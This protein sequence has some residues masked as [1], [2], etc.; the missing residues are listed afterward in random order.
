MSLLIAGKAAA[1]GRNGDALADID[2]AAADILDSLVGLLGP[3]PKPQAETPPSPLTEE[4]I[5]EVKTHALD[6]SL[7]AVVKRMNEMK[8]DEG[9]E[10]KTLRQYESF[11]SLFS[12]LTGIS[13]VIYNPRFEGMIETGFA[14]N[15]KFIKNIFGIDFF[16]SNR[17]PTLTA[18]ETLDTSGITIPAPAA[19]DNGEIG[20]TVCQFWCVA[21]DM[22]TPIMG[23][24]RQMPE[25][26]GDRNVAKRQD[27]FY[28]TA[29]W[30]FGLQRPQSII[31]LVT[32][33][34]SY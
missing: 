21:D 29:R 2:A 22:H 32:N 19:T 13:D 28:A 11:V 26:E 31:S 25:V 33:S 27:E 34:S 17:L 8:R 10:E 7:I 6:P 4:H 18:Q 20:D 16:V 14:K 23:A 5:A 9:I 1:W 24:W 12:T 3:K 15:M 30:G